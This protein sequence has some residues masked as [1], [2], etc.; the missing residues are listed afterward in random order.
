MEIGSLGA[1]TDLS[2]A[3]G[4]ICDYVTSSERVVSN[5]V[6]LTWSIIRGSESDQRTHKPQITF[7][8]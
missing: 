5:R 1:G 8:I 6:N 7:R 4:S 2:L 3:V